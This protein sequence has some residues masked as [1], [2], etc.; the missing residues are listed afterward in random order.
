MK[1][2][3]FFISLWLILWLTPMGFAQESKTKIACIGNSITYGYTLPDPATQSYPALL[4]KK[5]GTDYV[6]KNFGHS[7]ATLMRK[8]QNPYY[9]T[10][11][12]AEALAFHPD[13]AIL[14]LGVNDTDPRT[15]PN[16]KDNFIP[17]YNRL[18]DTLLSVN[19]E[20]RIFICSLMPVFTAHPRFLS[21][22][23]DWFWEAQKKIKRIVETRQLQYIDLY[24]AFH[25]RPDLITDAWTLHPNVKGAAKMSRVVYKNITGDFG[26]LKVAGI[27]TDNM[28]LQRDKPIKVWGIADAGTTIKVVFN[29]Q[30]E[31]VQTP[32]DGQWE[33]AFPASKASDRPHTLDITDGNR[34]VSYHN[35]LIGD[36]WLCAGQSNM[37]YSLAEAT[38]GK[39]VAKNAN[40]H[41]NLRLFKYTP[42]AETNAVAWDS[43]TLTKANN[44]DWFQGIWELNEEVA[45]KAFSAV[46]YWFGKK[47]QQEE[48]IPIGLIELAVG[49][50][51]QI[52]WVSRLTLEANPLFEPA[53]N[54]WRQSDYIMQ[55]CRE[56]ANLNL[57]K[58][59]S[60]YQRHPYDPAFNFEAG[61]SKITKFPIKGVIWYQGESDAE[62]PELYSKL[63]PVFVKDWRQHWGYDFPFYYVQLSSLDRPSWPHFRD[64][65]R[66]L[67]EVV[68]NSGMA[69]S[70]D[71]G[72]RTNVHYNNKK[73]VGLRLANLALWGTYKEEKVFPNGPLVQA[74][75]AN[76]NKILISF[77]QGKGLKTSD[78]KPLRGFEIL[79]HKGYFVKANASI[80]DEHV[81]LIIPEDVH[82]DKIVYGWQ[83]FTTANLVN[84][85][86]LPAS[87]FMI[88]IFYKE[89]AMK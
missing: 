10:R 86:G 23:F 58:T 24:A 87:T 11:Q 82:A 9:K 35:I 5:L 53:L 75:V 20:M 3:F 29:Q 85:E 67:L 63:F 1:M 78:G 72:D 40:E 2:R 13:E 12:F 64:A 54:N 15:W 38:G 4:Q 84:E 44:L 6:V 66:R 69:V 79:N 26:G 80:K 52:S 71:V 50:S 62:N 61:I 36:V 41:E 89:R 56:R 32:S 37:Y 39:A 27:F 43:A 17:D 16:D 47:I 88:N 83:P 14:C 21:S 42:Y 7:G 77:A 8:G 74:A 19:P 45:A 28:V 46:G 73:P 22:T 51:P 49:G 68:P 70:S 33:V 18:I 31:T 55:W 25:D 81:I 65:Q 76:E 30:T 34:K 59:S 60:K 48:H 57:Q